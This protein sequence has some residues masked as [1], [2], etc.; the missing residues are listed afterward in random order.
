MY[1]CKYFEEVICNE[2]YA[3]LG[4]RDVESLIRNDEIQVC[5]TQFSMIRFNQR[6]I[7]IFITKFIHF[8]TNIISFRTGGVRRASFR[9]N[10]ELGETQ[11][12]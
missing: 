2:E 7:P 1:T 8:N 3:A 10:H 11:R 5:F 4:L 9:G 6:I 12:R